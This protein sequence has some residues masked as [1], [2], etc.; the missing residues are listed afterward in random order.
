MR[1]VWR[2][3]SCALASSR[4]TGACAPRSPIHLRL[5][6]SS[7]L[8]PPARKKRKGERRKKKGAKMTFHRSSITS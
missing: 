8:L 1:F 7:P 2:K 4:V 6:P 3:A 5:S